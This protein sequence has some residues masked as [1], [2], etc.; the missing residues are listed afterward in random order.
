MQKKEQR[1]DEIFFEKMKKCSKRLKK[2]R[3]KIVHRK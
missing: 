2:I 3:K 1:K